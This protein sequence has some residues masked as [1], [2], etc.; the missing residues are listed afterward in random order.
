M[1]AVV[2]TAYG[3]ADVL[4]PQ[5][6]PA[7]EAGAGQVVVDVTVAG[8]NYRDLWERKIE[9]YGYGGGRPP[10][11]AGIEGVGRVAALGDGVAGVSVGDRVGWWLGAGTYAEQTVVAA[12][13]LLPLPERL[14]DAAACAGITQGMTAHGLA[15]S[16]GDAQAG[17]WVLVHAAAGG[18]GLLLTQMLARRGV[19]VV[20]TTSSD[21]KAALARAAG[22]EVVLRYDE[23]PERVLELTE[24][25]GV[26]IV[27]DGVGKD[28]FDASLASLGVRGVL[29]MFGQASGNVPPFASTVLAD[30]SL[31]ICRFRLPHYTQTREELLSRSNDVFDWTADGSLDVRIG[32]RYPLEQAAQAQRDLEARRT[33]GKLLLDVG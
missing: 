7:P 16:V 12:D 22:A 32:G 3:E 30:K 2:V 15:H 14:D 27:Y 13:L 17:D 23:V 10:V 9:P 24:G 1:R 18:V 26:R 25:R 4:E 31:F 33:T 5:D 20:A 29:A 21:E 19:R 28:T 11:V 8:V 6:W